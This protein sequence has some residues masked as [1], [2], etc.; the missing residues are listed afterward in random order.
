MKI[1]FWGTRGSIPSCGKPFVKYGGHTT[2]VEL[3]SSSGKLIV[4][5]AGT[6]IRNLGIALASSC[7]ESF[8]ILFT[9]SHL[10]H[11]AGFPFFVPIFKKN[12]KIS[13]FSSANDL[14][15]PV[16]EIAEKTMHPPIFPVSF[17]TLPAALSFH[18]I[19][20]GNNVIEDINVK[21]IEL[22]HPDG[23]AGFRFEENGKSFV[24]L[25]DNELGYR[26]A[27][28]HFLEYYADFCKGADFLVHDAQYTEEEYKSH[29]TWGHST[30]EQVLNLAKV[31]G[32][33]KLCLFHHDPGRSDLELDSLLAD[34]LEI[35]SRSG[36]GIDCMA[37]MDGQS[38]E[39]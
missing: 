25:T 38:I 11:I 8:S 26:H 6:G 1:K 10:D 35:N 30:P 15:D 32:V 14:S 12:M 39:I 37:A 20:K 4:I 17:K 7:P 29:K 16:K 21:P 28:G 3:R 33:K 31:A 36:Y 24:F 5:D 27:N 23:G 34:L 2:C 22:S 9:H 13:L 19:E 18:H